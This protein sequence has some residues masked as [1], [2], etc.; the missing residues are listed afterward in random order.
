MV[1]TQA[2]ADAD[3]DA[4]RALVLGGRRFRS[5]AYGGAGARLA[6]AILARETATAGGLRVLVA[7]PWAAGRRPL[8]V[9]PSYWAPRGFEQLA[10]ATHDARFRALERDSARLAAALTTAAPHLPPDWAAVGADGTA[11][12]TTVPGRRSGLPL[13]SYAAARLPVRVAESCSGAVRAL[14]AAEWPFFAAQDPDRIGLAYRLDGTRV[15]PAQSAVMLV[16]AAAA[17]RAAGNTPGR[18]ALLARA[19]AIDARFPTYYGAA[20]VALGSLELATSRL[21]GCAA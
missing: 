2:A 19:A 16:A 1:N 9:S 21:G 18:D 12:P 10:A 11:R 17:A 6:G 20:W 8:A 14:G 3:L 15:L 7:G 13:F 5:R 4:A